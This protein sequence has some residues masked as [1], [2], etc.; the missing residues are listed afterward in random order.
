MEPWMCL[1]VYDHTITMTQVPNI[2][3]FIEFFGKLIWQDRIKEM[4]ISDTDNL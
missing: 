4:M 2:H 3:G 1:P